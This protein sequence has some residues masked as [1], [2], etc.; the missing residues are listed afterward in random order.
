MARKSPEQF[1]K[2][3]YAIHGDSMTLLESYTETR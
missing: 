2:E 3:F 1:E